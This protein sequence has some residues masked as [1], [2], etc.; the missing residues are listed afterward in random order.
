MD[1][2]YKPE[3]GQACFGQPWQRLEL[4]G[5]GGY[6]L[7]AMRSIWDAVFD[8]DNPFSN[9]GAEYKGK[10]FKIYAYSWSNAEQ[11]FNFSWRDIRISWYKYFGRGTI[12]NREMTKKEISEMIQEYIDELLCGGK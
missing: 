3:L 7:D 12:I 5:K 10:K 1:K 8:E 6:A 9:T 4:S 11:P 2:L